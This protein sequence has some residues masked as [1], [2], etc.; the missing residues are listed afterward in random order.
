MEEL[1]QLSKR[2]SEAEGGDVNGVV[3]SPEE[4]RKLRR[5]SILAGF[6]RKISKVRKSLLLLKRF[7]KNVSKNWTKISQLICQYIR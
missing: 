6:D 2:R 3:V 7:V 1:E 4:A 5:L